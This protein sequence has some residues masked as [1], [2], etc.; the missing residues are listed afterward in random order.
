[1]SS[2]KSGAATFLTCNRPI[3]NAAFLMFLFCLVAS[4]YLS[5]KS[6]PTSASSTKVAQ[7]MVLVDQGLDFTPAGMLRYSV[8][9]QCDPNGSFIAELNHSLTREGYVKLGESSD[10]RVYRKAGSDIAIQ[11]DHQAL[12]ELQNH[13]CV[14]TSALRREFVRRKGWIVVLVVND[15][16]RWCDGILNTF[17]H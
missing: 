16:P 11:V 12:P 2:V 13:A 3:R 8:F 1:M 6:L 15:S 10:W 5:L 14:P 17:S 4:A 9:S 7:R